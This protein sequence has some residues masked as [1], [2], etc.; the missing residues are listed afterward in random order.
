MRPGFV[1]NNDVGNG[2][3]DKAIG[4]QIRRS[5]ILA[6]GAGHGLPAERIDP[7]AWH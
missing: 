5:R 2:F 6:C 3:Y 7:S 1:T 4:L